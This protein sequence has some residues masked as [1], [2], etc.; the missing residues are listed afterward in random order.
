MNICVYDL[1]LT[2]MCEEKLGLNE[3]RDGR[4]VLAFAVFESGY[5]LSLLIVADHPNRYTGARVSLD[6]H[7][8]IG[9]FSRVLTS[10]TLVMVGMHLIPYS[11]LNLF[12]GVFHLHSRITKLSSA[13]TALC[14]LRLIFEGG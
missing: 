4:D 14:I 13:F 11:F 1:V 8:Q 12:S 9:L 10:T 7:T 3:G 6:V 2:V 5:F